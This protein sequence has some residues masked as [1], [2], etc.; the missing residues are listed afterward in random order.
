MCKLCQKIVKKVQILSQDHEKSNFTSTRSKFAAP[1]LDF[2]ATK[3]DFC[4]SKIA[5]V[6]NIPVYMIC[7]IFSCK[8]ISKNLYEV[9]IKKVIFFFA[10]SILSL[11]KLQEEKKKE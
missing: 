5:L 6:H 11:V 1:K 3:A 7:A 9:S 8:D 10:P 2:T 4:C